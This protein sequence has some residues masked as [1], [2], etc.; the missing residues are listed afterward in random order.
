MRTPAPVIVLVGLIGLQFGIPALA[1]LNPIMVPFGWQMFAERLSVK[2][3]DALGR[4]GNVLEHTEWTARLRPEVRWDV[5]AP[6]YLCARNDW[7]VVRVTFSDGTV[8]DSVC[9]SLP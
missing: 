6:T 5:V 7:R 4:D 9:R 2:S 8:K 3:I 1:L